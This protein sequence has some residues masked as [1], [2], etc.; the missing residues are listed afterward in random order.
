MRPI[1][2]WLQVHLSNIIRSAARNDIIIVKR[3]EA[4]VVVFVLR[5]YILRR[6]SVIAYI[7]L[8]A[9]SVNAGNKGI[10]LTVSAVVLVIDVGTV[11]NTAGSYSNC[12]III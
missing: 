9:R 7:C 8:V 5:L 1:A 12:T 10:I 2:I 3:E 11:F 6:I 4:L